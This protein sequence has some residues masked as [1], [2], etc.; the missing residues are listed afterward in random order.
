M[1]IKII[2]STEA[3]ATKEVGELLEKLLVEKD[4]DVKLFE[5]GYLD[6]PIILDGFDLVIFGSPTYYGGELETKM[7]ELLPKLILDLSL[8][9]VAVFGL[10]DSGYTHF[11]GAVEILE[12]W[13]VDHQGA[14]FIPSLKIDRY[15]HYPNVIKNWVE[16]L[17]IKLLI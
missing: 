7:A 16:V 6:Q 15:P 10:G 11:C 8:Y 4:H 12:R 9:K 2:F 1:K 3:G 13:V 14:L 5:V 17:S